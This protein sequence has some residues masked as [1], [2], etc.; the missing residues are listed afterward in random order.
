MCAAASTPRAEQGAFQLVLLRLPRMDA[1]LFWLGILTPILIVLMV[2]ATL[3][4]TSSG[5]TE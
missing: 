4:L 1:V 3:L 2:F 5:N